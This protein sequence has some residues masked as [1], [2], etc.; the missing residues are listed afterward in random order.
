[1]KLL[2]YLHT[3]L[4]PGVTV[5]RYGPVL[6]TSKRFSDGT[7][8]CKEGR[9]AAC[10]SQS[11]F[12]TSQGRSFSKKTHLLRLCHL[13]QRVVSS[14]AFKSLQIASEP[15]EPWFDPCWT[16]PSCRTGARIW[17]YFHH[18]LRHIALQ[19]TIIFSVQ[20]TIFF[21]LRN[22]VLSHH[23]NSNLFHLTFMPSDTHHHKA[24]TPTAGVNFIIF[25]SIVAYWWWHTVQKQYTRYS[26]TTWTQ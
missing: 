4:Q 23:Y 8:H 9:A 24:L 21:I 6:R 3:V 15:S 19:C 25:N 2:I 16:E 12:K 5:G 14:V 7:Y 10:Q 13:K 20:I 22:T 18:R 1:M 26:I 17:K 11:R